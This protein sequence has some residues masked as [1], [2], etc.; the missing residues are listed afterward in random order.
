MEPGS[1]DASVSIRIQSRTS[2]WLDSGNESGMYENH[3]SAIDG[4]IHHRLRASDRMPIS[5]SRTSHPAKPPGSIPGASHIRDSAWLRPRRR[6][7][8]ALTAPGILAQN[9]TLRINGPSGRAC[10]VPGAS[11]DHDWW[12]RCRNSLRLLDFLDC[13]R[14]EC[15]RRKK[16]GEQG[17]Q[18]NRDDHGVSIPR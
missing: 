13:H 6:S 7:P 10:N 12:L 8:R 15:H 2:N 3:P 17:E 1:D 5:I 9:R 16:N 14:E 11:A 18:G 4:V